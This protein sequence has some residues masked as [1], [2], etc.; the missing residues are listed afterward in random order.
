MDVF[1]WESD[2]G[3]ELAP[4]VN[5]GN[6]VCLVPGITPGPIALWPEIS[7]HDV[8]VCCHIGG[9]HFV[10]FWGNWPG[11]FCGWYIASDEDGPGFGSPRTKI[12][13]D[14]GYPSGWQHP[15]VVPAFTGCK[16]LGIR[17]FA[18]LGNCPPTPVAPTTWGRIKSLH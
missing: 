16:D 3:A 15:N 6:V 8:Q 9:P 1:M 2:G 5:P 7:V 10:G 14:I 11:S 12:A 4:G 17:E 13:Q 18:G